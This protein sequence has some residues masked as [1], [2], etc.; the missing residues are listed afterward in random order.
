MHE[1]ATYLKEV[2]GDSHSIKWKFQGSFS[3]FKPP[4]ELLCFLIWV[5]IGSD[6]RSLV[7][8]KEKDVKQMVKVLG[9]EMVHSFSA[10][11]AM[12]RATAGKPAAALCRKF[13]RNETPL[14]VGIGL[15]THATTGSKK[16]ITNLS[17]LA[18]SNNYKNILEIEESMLNFV[19]SSCFK[20][21]VYIPP[22]NHPEHV[23]CHRQLLSCSRH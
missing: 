18:V 1:A 20:D 7:D 12:K 9:Q 15:S 8:I 10:N 4:R 17:D 3:D 23:F 14:T 19:L 6:E 22:T 11:R 5:R 2:I 16:V 13:Y 21:G